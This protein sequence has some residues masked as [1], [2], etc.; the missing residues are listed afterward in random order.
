MKKISTMLVLFFLSVAAFAQSGSKVQWTFVSKKI[1]DK[2]YEVK[3]TATIQ[4]GWHMYSQNQSADAIVLPTK[5][6]FAKNPL[7]VISGKPK[8]V[9]KLY[10]QFDKAIQ[11]RS[12]YYSNKVEFIQMVTIKSNVNTSVVGEVEFM[13]CDDKQCLPPD[14]AKFSIKL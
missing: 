5:V 12:K 11:A 14:R 10:D 2:K 1:S 8:E 7:L 3:I 6:T 4:P 13:V 9:G